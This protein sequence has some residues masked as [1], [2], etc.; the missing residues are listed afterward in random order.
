MD[1][2]GQQG[3]LQSKTQ[4]TNETDEG[5]ESDM[6]DVI[7]LP[8]SAFDADILDAV[9]FDDKGNILKEAQIDLEDVF[10]VSKDVGRG[11]TAHVHYTLYRDECEVALKEFKFGRLTE[12]IMN[13]FEKELDTLRKLRHPNIALLVGSHIDIKS[14]QLYLV[15]EWLPGG[16]LFDV[17][18]DSNVKITFWDVLT[19]S[20]DV[21]RGMQ[22]LHEQNIVH[23]DLKSH[24][25]LLDEQ[26]RVKVTDFGTAKHLDMLT[27]TAFTEVGTGG[28][29]APEV[30]EPVCFIFCL[31]FTCFCLI[32]FVLTGFLFGF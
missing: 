13:N 21:A 22:Y 26:H 32:S 11:R 17:L 1:N 29:M 24:N 25:L 20:L 18:N 14:N 6:D 28:Y 10:I 19:M 12:K 27:G 5:S 16:C 15:L 2:V 9:E 30:V 23:R 4:E 31:F 7:P 8:E 3:L